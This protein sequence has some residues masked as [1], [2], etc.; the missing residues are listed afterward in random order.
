MAIGIPQT[1]CIDVSH[2]IIRNCR[3]YLNVSLFCYEQGN[4][5]R[6]QTLMGRCNCGQRL[7]LEV[8]RPE[9]A[10]HIPRIETPV[11]TVNFLHLNIIIC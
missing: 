11:V 5:F 9:L 2:E 7:N 10:N 1:I 6:L 8:R 4:K 3:A